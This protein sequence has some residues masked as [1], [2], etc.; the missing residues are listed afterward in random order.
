MKIAMWSGPRNLSTALMYSFGARDDFD[1]V[2]EPFYGSY[3][4]LT[5][6]EHPMRDEIIAAMECDPAKVAQDMAAPSDTHVYVKHMTQHMVQD[7]PRD[8]FGTVKHAF[9]IRHPARVVASYHAKRERPSLEDIGFI[10]QAEIFDQVRALG[11]D[12]V[13]L[14][15]FDLRANPEAILRKLCIALDLDWD[16]AMLCWPA[17]GHV[18][19]GVWAQHWY[20]AVHA[21]SGFAGPEGDLPE[22][23]GW[24]AEV[25]DQALPY[26]QHMSAYKI[27][28]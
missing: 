15:S 22:L 25:A 16:P 24:A 17:G 13:V 21:S 9:L 3:L 10:Q 11:Q 28:A 1:V 26:F 6:V 12:A 14:D 2:D 5:G 23:D 7:V 18:R 8:W 27:T 20:N 4:T 19:D